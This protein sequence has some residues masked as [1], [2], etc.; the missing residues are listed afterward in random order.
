MY[1]RKRKLSMRD[2]YVQ[3]VSFQQSSEVRGRKCSRS[4]HSV[5]NGPGTV[6]VRHRTLRAAVE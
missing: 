1:S 2:S 5:G 6:P 4:V 3:I